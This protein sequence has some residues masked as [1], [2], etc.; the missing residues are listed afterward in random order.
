MASTIKDVDTE[1]M[2]RLRSN[3]TCGPLSN[4]QREAVGA[5]RQRMRDGY[6][7]TASAEVREAVRKRVRVA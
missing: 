1:A 2:K 7:F 3:A 4:R 6:A 5:T